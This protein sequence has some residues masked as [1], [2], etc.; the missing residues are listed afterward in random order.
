MAGKRIAGITIEIGGDTTKLQSSLKG[1]DKQLSTTKSNL[2]DVD[3]LLKLNPGN[4]TLL[5][6]KQKN[7]NKAISTTKDR[8][9]AL[10]QAQTDNLT[11]EEYDALQREIIETEGELK[12]LEDQYKEF[13][14]VG[15]Q[16]AIAVGNS[17]KSAGEKIT[18]VGTSITKYVTLPII[19]MGAAAYAA[20]NEVDEGMDTL[21]LK[22]G[23]SGD[24][25][26]EMADIMERIATT[27]P[28][29][30]ATAG[31]AVGEV[32]T[33]FGV[34]G[35]RL[36]RLSTLYIE[37][38]K[39]NGTDVTNAVDSS[40]KALSAFGLHA[41]AAE[42]YLNYLT[43]ASQRTGVSVDALTSG[44]VANASVFDELNMS[45]YDATEFLAQLEMSGI[46]SNEAM[47]G[48]S[49]AMKNAA[50]EGK[51]MDT[52]LADLYNTMK[53]GTNRTEGLNA[54]YE[55]F[56]KSGAQI[57]AAVRNGTLDFRNLAKQSRETGNTVEDTFNAILDP[58]DEFQVVMNEIKATGA[59]IAGMVMPA[60]SA[61]LKKVKKA[62]EDLTAKWNGL[63]DEQKETILK[64]LGIIAVV[65]PLITMVGKLVSGVGTLITVLAGHGGL[66]A[67]IGAVIAAGILIY[68]NWDTIKAK[69]KEIWEKIVGFFQDG[70]EK[71]KNI[72]W[73]A[74]GEAIWTKVKAPF[75]IAGN[76]FKEKF[77]AVKKA[78][79]E[80]NWGEL[81]QAIWDTIKSKFGDVKEWF[82][83]KFKDAVN[84]V[85]GL[86]NTMIG[87]AEGAINKVVN[88]INSKLTVNVDFGHLPA[89]LGGGS[90]GGIHWSPNIKP[91]SF[92]RIKY[93]AQGGSI[94]EGEQ[95]YVGEL[96][97]ERLRV[98]NGRA[99]VTPIPGAQRGGDTTFNIYAQP[100]Q[101]AQQIAQEVQ[102]ILVREQRQR[103]AAYA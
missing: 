15:K 96:A 23:A 65:G 88:G 103:S 12:N 92:S 13:G 2:K 57:Y 80:I 37:F 50:K 97:P 9:K 32:N 24:A 31:E 66:I 10:K 102:R 47:S 84:A 91:A 55:L 52:A 62:I 3:K 73:K 1:V 27:I 70:W 90:L 93:L 64:V 7:L 95:A 20:F 34:T 48:L 33:R 19:G 16:K 4:T 76:W 18:D 94:G 25:L 82:K 58:S 78:I 40:Q 51:P 44:A 61:V 45:I 100:G 43:D 86:L 99:V 8:L 83:Q 98:I 22:T 56:G 42:H 101:S 79:S 46:D 63:D 67:V 77:D 14:S 71:I 87:K 72:D 85:I 49:K 74:L 30:F 17:L 35:D 53:Y 36:E 11:T 29:D 6:Q 38:A 21:I 59:S 39:I 5:T 41:N 26:D 68:K 69:A 60:L 81:G 89:F 75:L 54:A 28:T